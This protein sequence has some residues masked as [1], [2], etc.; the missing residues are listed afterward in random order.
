MP[1]LPILSAA[2]RDTEAAWHSYILQTYGEPIG[3]NVIDLNTFSWFYNDAPAVRSLL[4]TP[5]LQVCTVEINAEM[6]EGTPWIGTRGPEGGGGS[7]SWNFGV[8]SIGFFVAR[9]FI[10]PSSAPTCSRIEVMHVYTSWAG[11]E[12]GVSWFYNTVGSGIYLDCA[13]LPTAGRVAAYTN[14]DEFAVQEG[15]DWPGD[16]SAGLAGVME[17][18]GIAML[19]ITEATYNQAWGVEHPNARTEIIV[20]QVQGDSWP[21]ASEGEL[22]SRSCLADSQMGFRFKTGVG[23]GRTCTCRPEAYLNCHG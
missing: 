3:S 2:N 12:Q 17:E 6:Y 20:R 14:R 19:I 15:R 23:G 16:G 9:P 4:S 21:L 18:M 13:D 10:L 1:Q 5:C 7:D 8:G 22:P 11:E